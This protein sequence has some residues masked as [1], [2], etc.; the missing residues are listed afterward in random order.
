MKFFLTC[1]ACGRKTAVAAGQAGQTVQCSCGQSLEVPSIR[2]L[3]EMEPASEEPLPPLWTKRKGLIFLGSV[4]TLCSLAF[5][6]VIWI[7]RPEPVIPP[8]IPVDLKAVDQEVQALS[9]E[10][11]FRRYAMIASRVPTSFEERLH[12][13]VVPPFL[14]LSAHQLQEFEGTGPQAMASKQTAK[15]AEQAVKQN[16]EL[17]GSMK[18]RETLNQW[19][20]IAGAVAVGGV[21]IACS[22]LLVRSAASQNRAQRK[23]QE[24]V[25]R[26]RSR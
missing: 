15:V 17:V 8:A 18:V 21:L 11:G 4:V 10:E 26:Q 24:R 6:I 1:P 19:L 25:D 2:Q 5:A 9:P 22:A 20:K 23:R 12:D 13:K 3:R 7:Y 14:M 16:M